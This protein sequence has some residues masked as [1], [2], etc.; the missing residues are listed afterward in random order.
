[1]M[2][3]LSLLLAFTH[4]KEETKEDLTDVHFQNDTGNSNSFE[5]KSYLMKGPNKL[6]CYIKQGWK[7]LSEENSLAYWT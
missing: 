1:M 3:I 6:G 2:I 7:G 4:S 5:S